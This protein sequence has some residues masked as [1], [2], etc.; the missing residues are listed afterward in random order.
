MS[1]LSYVIPTPNPK[2]MEEEMNKV[3]RDLRDDYT[4]VKFNIE[5]SRVVELGKYLFGEYKRL[6]F[7]FWLLGKKRK[8][9]KERIEL[10]K[11]LLKIANFHTLAIKMCRYEAQHWIAAGEKHE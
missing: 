4:T 8:L 1:Y 2:A 5:A 11:K 10:I 6:R 9:N 7:K 3:A